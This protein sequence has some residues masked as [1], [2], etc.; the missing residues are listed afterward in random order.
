V[1]DSGYTTHVDLPVPLATYNATGTSAVVTDHDGHGALVW[2][3]ALARDN[4]TC[5]VGAAP[6]AQLVA[7][8]VIPIGGLLT[9]A[10][11]TRAI[12]WA[13]TATISDG[14]GGQAKSI[15]VINCSYQQISGAPDRD[16]EL[17]CNRALAAGIVQV[18]T[19]GNAN[20]CGPHIIR[21][22]GVF[23]S[24]VTVAS[25]NEDGDRLFDGD[26]GASAEVD[27][28]AGGFN[29]VGLGHPNL[30]NAQNSGTSFAAPVVSGVTALLFDFAEADPRLD[31]NKHVS[32]LVRQAL[33]MGAVDL[34]EDDPSIV[35][36]ALPI[37]RDI[38]TGW[39]LVNAVAS[40][41]YLQRSLA[42]KADYDRSGNLDGDDLADFAADYLAASPVPGPAGYAVP[43][44]I[45]M[46][47]PGDVK[48][49][50]P[51]D[52]LGYKCDFDQ[53]GTVTPDDLADFIAAFMAGC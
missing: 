39:G 16:E 2:G 46:L 15:R 24:P 8:K 52:E 4:G 19:E 37:G 31:R 28:V 49:P 12:V 53:D 9:T 14:Q 41:E 1:L 51:F 23:E 6:S 36:C 34:V 26:S 7:V 29:V 40:L 33:L 47:N 48:P 20:N 44:V 10:I 11:S 35:E 25:V 30:C 3:F 17:A 5:I 45:T 43:A 38:L 18:A 50:A 42:C 32:F 27:V 22:P 21:G 13:T